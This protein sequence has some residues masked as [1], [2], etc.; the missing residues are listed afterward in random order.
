MAETRVVVNARGTRLMTTRATLG[1]LALP[2][3]FFAGINFDSEATEEVFLDHGAQAVATMLDALAAARLGV[4]EA[5]CT[6]ALIA[7]RD[8]PALRCLLHFVGLEWLCGLHFPSRFDGPL[9][10]E[11]GEA[12]CEVLCQRAVLVTGDR[13]DLLQHLADCQ[14]RRS[15]AELPEVGLVDEQARLLGAGSSASLLEYAGF[16]P[17]GES[18]TY[19]EGGVAALDQAE[20][21][22]RFASCWDKPQA[23]LV[24]DAGEGNATLVSGVRFRIQS[25]DATTCAEQSLQLS[26]RLEGASEFAAGHAVLASSH[27][28]IRLRRQQGQAAWEMDDRER[29]LYQLSLPVAPFR[30]GVFRML[31]LSAMAK[32]RRIGCFGWQIFGH[33]LQNIPKDLML[34]A[35]EQFSFDPAYSSYERVVDGKMPYHGSAGFYREWV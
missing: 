34:C 3:T 17:L 33:F 7:S 13:L 18:K 9:T 16:V 2:G 21:R 12:Q 11:G 24:F 1:S 10:G 5:V 14:G 4:T 29:N 22:L 25:P 6:V 19:E 35:R 28:D 27:F 26:V 32:G 8:D 15:W 23:R 20:E 31:R 30:Q